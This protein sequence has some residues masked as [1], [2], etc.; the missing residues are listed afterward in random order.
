M[1]VVEEGGLVRVTWAGDGANGRLV[2]DAEADNPSPGVRKACSILERAA[3]SIQFRVE[4]GHV[5]GEGAEVGSYD[6]A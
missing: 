4:N 5:A 6:R 3:G 2:V 1:D